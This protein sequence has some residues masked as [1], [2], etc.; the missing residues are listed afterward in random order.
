MKEDTPAGPLTMPEMRSGPRRGVV[1]RSQRRT[2]GGVESRGRDEKGRG[3]GGVNKEAW[4]GFR[5]RRRGVL[6]NKK[7]S[8]VGVFHRS[9]LCA[10]VG[11]CRSS[12][13]T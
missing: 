2:L 11:V 8:A 13:V 9:E 3:L 7:G 4:S 12:S 6:K 5:R 1:E 10:L